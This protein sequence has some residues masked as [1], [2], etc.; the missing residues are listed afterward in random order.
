MFNTRT[1]DQISRTLVLLTLLIVNVLFFQPTFAANLKVT[2]AQWKNNWNHPGANTSRSGSTLM[3]QYPTTGSIPSLYRA[4]FRVTTNAANTLLPIYISPLT[5]K[6]IISCK[7]IT[8]TKVKPI[9]ESYCQVDGNKALQLTAQTKIR[10]K[11]HSPGG[12]TKYLYWTLVPPYVNAT[13]TAPAKTNYH[14]A[15]TKLYNFYYSSRLHGYTFKIRDFYSKEDLTKYFWFQKVNS[16]V[17]INLGNSKK[18]ESLEVEMFGGKRTLKPGWTFESFSYKP[19]SGCTPK[20][21]NQSR[22]T[23]TIYHRFTLFINNDSNNNLAKCWRAILTQ[24]R[25]KGPSGKNPEDALR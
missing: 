5:Q 10:L 24:I 6:S 15:G 11:I 14:L 18:Q 25:L 3:T 4:Y 22:G 2:G 16:G 13:P 19:F 21:V 8:P 1:T 7:N 12:G 17:L 20:I 23:S 9:Y